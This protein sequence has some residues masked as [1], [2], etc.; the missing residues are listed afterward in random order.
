MIGKPLSL[1]I[2]YIAASGKTYFWFDNSTSKTMDMI[3]C[4]ILASF[5]TIPVLSGEASVQDIETET[6]WSPFS[7]LI[8]LYE[9]LV[10]RFI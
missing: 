2:H 9:I 10:S 3:S 1:Y 6:K 4:W 5:F 7:K 8:S